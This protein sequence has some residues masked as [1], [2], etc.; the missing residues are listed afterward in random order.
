M[1]ARLDTFN[2]TK[3][4]TVGKKLTE[5]HVVLNRTRMRCVQFPKWFQFNG[6]VRDR[7]TDKFL[8]ELTMWGSLRL[9]PIIVL[10]QWKWVTVRQ[11]WITD[12]HRRTWSPQVITSKQYCVLN[13][14]VS[15]GYQN[16][17]RETTFN[18]SVKLVG[19][20]ELFIRFI[21][22]SI[23]NLYQ[24]NWI[25]IN[26]VWIIHQTA[27]VKQFLSFISAWTLQGQLGLSKKHKL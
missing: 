22:N 14:S 27:I 23:I 7:Q 6:N 4:F 3:R 26:T 12:T 1:P 17:S 25:G 19:H 10:K 11:W 21:P 5:L 15:I 9:A 13:W 24:C 8:V 18:E 16:G 2:Y 20:R